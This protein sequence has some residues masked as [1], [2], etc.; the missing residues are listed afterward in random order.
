[1]LA[2]FLFGA[3]LSIAAV[4]CAAQ[5]ASRDPDQIVVTGKALEG[6]EA[7]L[8]A[9]IARHCPPDQEIGAAI[10]HAENQFV[11]GRYDGAR[12]TLA[13]ASRRNKRYAS[14]YPVPVS[15]M[16]RA[17]SRVAAHLGYGDE[18][19]S[20]AL[21]V[22]AALKAGLANDDSRVL[23]AR[24]EL[25]DAYIKTGRWQAASELYRTVADDAKRLH[26]PMVEGFARF[27]DAALWASLAQ[28]DKAYR[29][30][31]RTKLAALAGSTEPAHAP[32]A[33]AAHVLQTRLAA[34]E[35]DSAAVDA[36]IAEFRAQPVRSPVLL[37][38]DPI[39]FARKRQAEQGES[40]STTRL[41]AMEDVD[42][43]WID[44]GFWIAP[45]GRTT[46]VDI[47]RDSGATSARWTAPV[48]KS[49]RSRR[50]AP[51]ALNGSDPGLFRVERYTLTAH[52]TKAT[53][54][55]MAVRE[56]QPRLE[57]LDLS[58]ENAVPAP[59]KLESKS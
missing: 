58:T 44:V 16:L 2:K 18:Y 51:L 38:S 1:M 15:D 30:N 28:E 17:K 6:T 49:I 59:V 9:C 32:F 35:G 20:D 50:Y 33:K 57:M 34:R 27:R 7:A 29:G 40:G 24:T 45:D 46:D 31:A 4:P 11:A 52:W 8:A 13:A 22:I 19:F 53:G 10:A 3:G 14:Q 56:A 21:D 36:L 43:Q 48:L 55:R 12:A 54:S 26:Y 23:V 5:E 41:M 39:E 42:N 37:A 47:L 25:A